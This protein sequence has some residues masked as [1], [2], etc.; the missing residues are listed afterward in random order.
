MVEA[1]GSLARYQKRRPAASDKITQQ[2]QS[3][4][5]ISRN[6][7][8]IDYDGIV[9]DFPNHAIGL[10]RAPESSAICAP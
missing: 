3:R 10:F 2:Q 6:D 1:R 5:L 8:M 7:H 9:V 4:P